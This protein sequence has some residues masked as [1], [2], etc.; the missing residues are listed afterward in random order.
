MP[1]KNDYLELFMNT[2]DLAEYQKYLIRRY[3]QYEEEEAK[4][5][6]QLKTGLARK[7]PTH[8][9]GF[10]RGEIYVD[11]FIAKHR[12]EISVI[13]F[14]MQIRYATFWSAYIFRGRSAESIDLI[15]AYVKKALKHPN[16]LKNRWGERISKDPD[17]YLR[18]PFS[19]LEDTLLQQA[20]RICMI[21]AF[22]IFWDCVGDYKRKYYPEIRIKNGPVDYI[23]HYHKTGIEDRCIDYI[24]REHY[25]QGFAMGRVIYTQKGCRFGFYNTDESADKIENLLYKIKRREA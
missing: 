22:L 16:S 21:H 5:K 18:Y 19:K 20:L 11:E 7:I 23:F 6:E 25:L 14:Y 3:M 8:T 10:R 15:K 17:R 12:E 4:K 24:R 13:D 1:T 2:M 9:Y